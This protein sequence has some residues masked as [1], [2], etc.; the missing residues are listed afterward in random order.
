MYITPNAAKAKLII[1]KNIIISSIKPTTPKSLSGI[2][3]KG[4]KIYII[5]KKSDLKK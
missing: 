2:K 3:S 1:T 4:S 5:P